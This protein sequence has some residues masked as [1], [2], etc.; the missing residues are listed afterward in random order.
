VNENSTASLGMF[1]SLGVLVIFYGLW[2][3]FSLRK[4]SFVI[5]YASILFLVLFLIATIGGLGDLFAY[6]ISPQIRG[7][8]RI[9]I[10]LLFPIL[11]AFWE[12][13]SNYMIKLSK[14]PKLSILSIGCMVI[15]STFGLMEQI[16]K[17][18]VACLMQQKTKFVSD[19]DFIKSIESSLPKSS[20]IYQLPYFNYLNTPP[21]NGLGNYELFSGFLNSKELKWSFGGIQGREGDLFYRSLSR[22]SPS[23]QLP[24]LKQ[25]G[26]SGVYIDVRGY[27]DG[28]KDVIGLWTQALG[29]KPI[30]ISPNR[31]EYFFQLQG[32]NSSGSKDYLRN[33]L[34]S[35]EKSVNYS[36][37][38]QV[39]NL[40]DNFDEILNFSSTSLPHV[41]QLVGF[42]GVENWGRWTDQNL[43]R[44][45]SIK[46]D[47]PL[48]TNFN[49]TLKLQSFGPNA[50]NPLIIQIGQITQVISSLKAQ[51]TLYRLYFRHV[52]SGVNSINIKPF[53]PASPKSLGLSNDI[54][55]LGIGII[56]MKFDRVQ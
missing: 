2:R 38:N 1:A 24:I 47:Q 44:V 36:S 15:A 53:K 43:S 16:P 22:L 42:S 20:A 39:F 10:F 13:S 14:Y 55:Q 28:G 11:I 32:S 7:W 5:R 9:S 30:L 31:A 4:T 3:I 48:P 8:N 25:M 27:A 26:F 56:S 37:A 50:G 33:D 52:G 49:L 45:A 21:L 19:K 34:D 46:F 6:L 29:K 35:L 51:P 23:T 40:V 54:R 41:T 12:V 18:C 17:S